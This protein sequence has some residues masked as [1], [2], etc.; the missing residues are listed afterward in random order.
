MQSKGHVMVDGDSQITNF[1]IDFLY[2]NDILEDQ[3]QC[4]LSPLLHYLKF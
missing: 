4:S 3:R 2:E 1:V